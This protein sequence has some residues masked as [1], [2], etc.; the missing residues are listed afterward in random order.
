MITKMKA[1]VIGTA[2]IIIMTG[3]GALEQEEANQVDYTEESLELV[4]YSNSRDSEESFEERFGDAIRE[5]F[6]NFTIKYIQNDPNTATFRH[7]FTSG[8]PIDIYWDSVGYFVGG[9]QESGLQYDMTDLI[10]QTNV[11][12]DRFQET[13]LEAMRQMSDGKL[14]G[15]PVTTNTLS[16]FYNQDLFDKFGVTYPTDGML[17]DELM[18]LNNRLTRFEDSTQYIGFAVSYGHIVR[19]NP[20]SQP[21]VNP[22]TNHMEINTEP[23]KQIYE[24]AFLRPAQAQGYSEE[25]ARKG[26]LPQTNEFIKD[27]TLAM[28]GFLNSLVFTQDMSTFN[29][30]MVSFP[31]FNEA[32]NRGPQ[33]YPTYFSITST[34][35][36]KEAAM[37]VIK[38]LT[39][40]E[41]QMRMSKQGHLPVI[42]DEEVRNA[43]GQDTQFSDKNLQSVFVNEMSPIMPKT[44]YDDAVFIQHYRYSK[45]I[46]AG[47]IDINTAFREMEEQ[48]NQAI[49]ELQEGT[50]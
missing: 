17:W 35:K 41:N 39:S 42:K 37:E 43:F 23:W 20:L 28:Y 24:N 21:L 30:D 18:E 27:K 15:L 16:L 40:D 50:D 2:F 3:C 36:H 48:G 14:Y 5:K 32:P 29:W 7:L 31:K 6:P 19:L 38:F 11:D 8:Q 10:E 12:L 34:S 13:D 45:E 1:F 33:G 46:A 25:V 22:E 44:L 26:A 9:I 4:F 47:N 49:K